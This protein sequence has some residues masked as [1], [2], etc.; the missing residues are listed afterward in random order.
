MLECA[1][2][3]LQSHGGR[4][5]IFSLFMVFLFGFLDPCLGARPPGTDTEALDQK[6]TL[7][8]IDPGL[9]APGAAVAD[10]IKRACAPDETTLEA[11]FKRKA[12]PF[13]RA[14][15]TKVPKLGRCHLYYEPT[16]RGFRADPDNFPV[17]EL[18]FDIDAA[19]F[20]ARRSVA[21]GDSLDIAKA[22]GSLSEGGLTFN[23][24]LSSDYSPEW[25]DS[26]RE[27]NFPNPSHR[28]LF[29]RNL[30]EMSNPWVQDYLK[31]GRVG[32]FRRVLLTRELIEGDV[33]SSGLFQPLLSSF[34]KSE[35]VRSN[36]SW[37]GGDLQFVLDPR[38]RSRLL[39]FYGSGAK[40]YWAMNLTPHEYAYVLQVEFGADEAIDFT[41]LVSH[42][43]YLVAFLPKDN[44]VLLGEPLLDDFQVAQGAF[45]ALKERFPTWEGWTSLN[46][47]SLRA[48][49]AADFRK[50]KKELA[51]ELAAAKRSNWPLREDPELY[52]KMNS[53]LSEHCPNDPK[54]CFSE[55]GREKL[56]RDDRVLFSD[57][58]TA[59]LEARGDERLP[60]RMLSVVESQLEGFRSRIGRNLEAKRKILEGLGFQV[61][62][63][64]RIAGDPDLGVPWSGISYVNSLLIDKTLFVPQFGLGPGEDLIYDELEERLPRGYQVVPV[65]ARRT[66]L[67]NGGLHCV[68][69]IVRSKPETALELTR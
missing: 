61:I 37:E 20:I 3:S 62:K 8:P 42:V 57:W 26:A 28:V 41:D 45:R 13:R 24:S 12:L 4:S 27:F 19:S 9:V 21:L 40:Q 38:D 43:D 63:V 55:E 50:S 11:F 51:Q 52:R 47:Q 44:I 60:G 46:F 39:M 35:F 65:Y 16:I 67:F 32:S 29:H 59:S 14:L 25:L 18:Y 36:L 10:S 15:V 22:I 66:L 56:A 7:V 48:M 2:R 49:S 31:S 58:V 68:V 6:V 69:G 23:L 17:S 34:S 33:G 53:Y 54:D 30:A 1:S 5:A 64:P